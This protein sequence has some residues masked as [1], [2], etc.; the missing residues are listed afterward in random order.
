[1]FML[2]FAILAYMFTP[3]L[4]VDEA[5]GRVQLFGGAFDIQAQKMITQLSK[6]G[7]FVFGTIA[8]VETLAADI[9][10]V[11]VI[12]GSGN[13]RIDYNATS[14][15][16]WDCDGAG[17]NSRASAVP[18]QGKLVLDFSAAFVDCDINVPHRALN[19]FAIAGDISVR[20]PKFPLKIKVERGDVEIAPAA[21]TPYKF[22]LRAQG[23]VSNDD[24]VSSQ[25]AEAV[26]IDV[27]VADGD[28]SKLE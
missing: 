28:I 20:Y 17:K 6:E 21:E 14:E 23:E 2:F 4:K 12:M 19:I 7:S 18:E 3:L 8:G 25:D 27:E 9:K 16:N 22:N 5:T 11:E 15:L 13:L 10:V 1:M 24:F 26:S